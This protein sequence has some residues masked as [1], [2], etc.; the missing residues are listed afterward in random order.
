MQ[1]A[2]VLTAAC[3]DGEWEYEFAT[4]SGRYW[5]TDEGVIEPSHWQVIKAP[6]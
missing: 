5:F 4:W 2:R 6:A 3:Y 1:N